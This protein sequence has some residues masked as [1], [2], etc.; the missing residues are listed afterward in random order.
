MKKELKNNYILFNEDDEVVKEALDLMRAAYNE[1]Q[2]YRGV[3]KVLNKAYDN[4]TDVNIGLTTRTQTP[5]IMRSHFIST[6]SEVFGRGMRFP[7]FK[8]EAKSRT[9][10]EIKTKESV[11]KSVIEWAIRSTGFEDIYQESKH[12]WTSF[13]DSYRRPYAIDLKRT[14]RRANKG[15]KPPGS[16]GNQMY[17]QYEDIDGTDLMFDMSAKYIKS[18]NEADSI[19]W[20][21]KT[22]IYNSRSLKR[23]FGK[24]ILKYAQEGA[25]VDADRLSTSQGNADVKTDK[26]Y[27]VIEFQDCG[28]EV[29]LVL[30]GAN[31]IP[32]LRQADGDDTTPPKEVEE[33][34]KWGNEYMHYNSV[35]NAYLTLQSNFFYWN[36]NSIRNFGLAHKLY[37]AQVAHEI[38]ENAKLDS[39]RKQMWEIP[40]IHGGRRDMVKENLESYKEEARTNILAFLHLPSNV[41]GILPTT[42]TFRFEGVSAEQGTRS[43][44]DIHNFARN[45][46]GVSLTRLEVQSGVGLGQTEIIED[47]KTVSVETIVQNN[48]SNLRREFIG[49][50]DY[51]VNMNGFNLDD[52]ITYT[53]YTKMEGRTREIEFVQDDAEISLK[54]AAKML[55]DFEFDLYIDRNSIVEKHQISM[56]GKIIDYLGV[57]DPAALPN[58]AKSLMNRLASIMRIDIPV[59]DLEGIENSRAM[60]GKSQ[61]QS[62]G[63]ETPDNITNQIQDA[64]IDQGLMEGIPPLQTVP[65]DEAQQ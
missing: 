63:Q 54:E 26:Y 53:K 64:E 51:V 37:G 13:G 23:R 21:A 24:D 52:K 38:V 5:D 14:N 50:I 25:M 4:P 62:G 45:A 40:V 43:T 12:N 36:R 3:F 9:N 61:F 48:V 1:L 59:E 19:S 55:S 57:V 56:A 11:A 60:G 17:M 2:T 20:W 16:G 30:I 42:S 32:V 44:D 39:T 27:E 10:P 33:I 18:E 28:N 58:V 31:A 47:E 34:V 15:A 46:V 8:I 29:E 35:G 6:A 65:R 7:E 49:L 22:K 41:Q